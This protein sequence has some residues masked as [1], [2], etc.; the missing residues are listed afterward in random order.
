MTTY[1]QPAA[2]T[3]ALASLDRETRG[4]KLTEWLRWLTEGGAA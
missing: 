4:A 1:T 3:E 2:L